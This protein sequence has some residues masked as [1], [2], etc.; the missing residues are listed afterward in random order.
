MGGWGKGEGERVVGAMYDD[1]GL[2]ARIDC[3][4]FWAGMGW[5]IYQENGLVWIVLVGDRYHASPSLLMCT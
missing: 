5:W 1:Y 4:A 3:T 2:Y